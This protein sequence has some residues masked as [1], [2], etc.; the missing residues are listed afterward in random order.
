M[1]TAKNRAGPMTS[2]GRC[3]S[4]S[5]FRERHACEHQHNATVDQIL[6]KLSYHPG[7]RAIHTR[8]RFGID[9]QPAHG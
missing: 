7:G 1:R 9:G 8:D 4:K 2:V 6:V 5:A 3:R